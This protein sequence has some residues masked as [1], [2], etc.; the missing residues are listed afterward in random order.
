MENDTKIVSFMDKRGYYTFG[1]QVLGVTDSYVCVGCSSCLTG[2]YLN[3]STCIKN[4]TNTP[5]NNIISNTTS[6]ITS[7]NSTLNTTTIN[8]ITNSTLP[9]NTT[10]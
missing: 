8:N 1:F 9:I 4:T 5:P 7:Q 2:Y 10:T 3:G 6:N